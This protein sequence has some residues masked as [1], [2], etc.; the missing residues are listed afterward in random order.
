MNAMSA[1]YHI[2]QND[3]PTL[4]IS[5]LVVSDTNSSIHDTQITYWSESFKNFIDLCL[6]KQPLNRPTANELLSHSFILIQSDRKAL[7]DLIRKTKET[8]RDLDNIGCRK[9]KKIIMVEGNSANSSS[10]LSG[11]LNLS[12]SLGGGVDNYSNLRDNGESESGGSSLLNLQN[13]GSET[14]QLEDTSAQ[15]DDEEEVIENNE[16]NENESSSI[17]YTINN[18][19]DPENDII[20]NKSESIQKLVTAT[21]NLHL[22]NKKESLTKNSNQSAIKPSISSS[23]LF[24]T[25]TSIL[26]PSTTPTESILQSTKLN[27]E[28][29]NQQLK[30]SV[31]MQNS[32]NETLILNDLLSSNKEMINLGD[33]LKRRVK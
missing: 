32:F 14:S 29:Q 21:T 31:D 25:N 27:N 24:F 13:D 23:K 19:S 3:S 16:E 8:V 28:E 10:G 7:V 22:N 5:Q 4:N 9:M 18:T 30:L 6:K 2:A 11:N 20:E 33:S 26:S 17:L 15:L 1:L 12:S